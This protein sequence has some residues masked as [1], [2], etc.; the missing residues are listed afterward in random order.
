MSTVNPDQFD[1]KIELYQRLCDLTPV[2]F[3]MVV[4]KLGNVDQYL[5]SS[6]TSLALRA[7]ELV[8][9][10]NSVD[11]LSRLEEAV[12]EV[13]RS[14]NT[15]KGPNINHVDELVGILFRST[16]PKDVL[17]LSVV[18][19]AFVRKSVVKDVQNI[20]LKD[21]E[22]LRAIIVELAMNC[23]Q[24]PSKVPLLAQFVVVLEV[25]LSENTGLQKQLCEW[26]ST[27]Y[28]NEF[29]R[30]AI[31]GILPPLP[32]TKHRIIWM[33][34]VWE[35]DLG[36]EVN[37][38]IGLLRIGDRWHRVSEKVGT[39]NRRSDVREVI[40][41][42]RVSPTGA[43]VEPS[44]VSIVCNFE[45][46]HDRWEVDLASNDFHPYPVTVRLS[47]SSGA[48][49]TCP[50]VISDADLITCADAQRWSEH[51]QDRGVFVTSE[52]DGSQNCPCSLVRVLLK[53]A[54]LGIWT[55]SKPES[56]G[57]SLVR[58]V[59]DK[60]LIDVPQQMHRRRTNSVTPD[61]VWRRIVVFFNPNIEPVDWSGMAFAPGL[62][63]NA[64][65]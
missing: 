37:T 20:G 51:V 65:L 26:F 43:Y 13:S 50:D 16:F 18:A 38:A 7:M 28:G 6:E 57:D 62:D 5:P 61:E 31:L 49:R 10:M 45:E 32:D 12:S 1:K 46:L 15:T 54:S 64:Q 23:S 27:H 40:S 29:D 9:H 24:Q 59:R 39:S 19:D 47:D 22:K 30:N 58:A 63:I 11:G 34:I 21:E 25:F 33:E 8:K 52:L 17:R 3:A 55:R 56:V 36:T 2:L 4:F 48:G 41:N 44:F 14:D 42:Y 53:I 60:H 35:S